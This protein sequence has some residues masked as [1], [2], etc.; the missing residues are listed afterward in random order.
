MPGKL[1]EN[2]TIAFFSLFSGKL[3]GK[4][5]D[6]QY[7]HN[8]KAWDELKGSGKFFENQPALTVMRYG[9][10]GPLSRRLFFHG[11]HLTAANNACEVIAVYNALHA[12]GKDK[13]LPELIKE[14]SG[15][16]VCANGCFGTSPKALKRYLEKEGYE[17]KLLVGKD[18]SDENLK[19]LESEYRVFLLTSFN[20]G[21]NPFHMVH[22]MCIS[23]EK[24][25]FIRHNDYRPRTPLESL[26]EGVYGYNEGE[27]R[28]ICLLA[29]KPAP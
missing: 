20:R 16:G 11:K 23:H 6:E 26:K 4:M 18:L 14:F 13:S 27:S 1:Y 3:S 25:G 9:H 2:L 5:T 7:K 28:P 8:I 19:S 29:V 10:A 15:R 12:F 22:T 24:D 21:Y 17:T